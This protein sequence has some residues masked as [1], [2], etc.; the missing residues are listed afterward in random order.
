MSIRHAVPSLAITLVF[1]TSLCT[2]K[3]RLRRRPPSLVRYIYE[4]SFYASAEVHETSRD[5]G[6]RLG[7]FS[8]DELG[9]DGVP[10]GGAD[11]LASRQ[12][13]VSVQVEHVHDQLGT[14]LSP[15]VDVRQLPQPVDPLPPATIIIIIDILEWP[16]Q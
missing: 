3:S 6:G 7:A 11:E 12:P 5:R 14:R 4:S 8:V 15:L 2:N 13:S 10:G 1:S 16:K 9:D